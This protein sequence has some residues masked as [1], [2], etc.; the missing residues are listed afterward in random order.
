M[1]KKALINSIAVILLVS[2][3][4]NSAFSQSKIRQSKFDILLEVGWKPF[5]ENETSRFTL[6]EKYVHD[7]YCSNL[8]YSESRDSSELYVDTLMNTYSIHNTSKQ[9]AYHSKIS[10]INQTWIFAPL[11]YNF[12]SLMNSSC[13]RVE[14][15]PS[16]KKIFSD[17]PDSLGVI[18]SALIIV[19]YNDNHSPISMVSK[20]WMDTLIQIKS[21]TVL[22]TFSNENIC[23]NFPLDSKTDFKIIDCKEGKEKL[24]D[25]HEILKDYNISNLLLS[26]IS[27]NEPA[28]FIQ[29][30]LD[31]LN[32][33][34]V[35]TEYC[36]P[37]HWFINESETSF[38]FLKTEGI[39]FISI[40]P[41]ATNSKSLNNLK[42]TTKIDFDIYLDTKSDLEKQYGINAFPTFLLVNKYGKIIDYKIGYRKNGL[43]DIQEFISRNKKSG[44]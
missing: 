17:I 9:T 13:S 8:F 32:L 40:I 33:I 37:C 14:E 39:K 41:S 20:I 36:L 44:Y 23:I 19:N 3:F 29:E 2:A 30:V 16:Q 21:Y 1:I 12:D 4:Y 15:T 18:D 26:N 22:K 38:S 6:R 11:K 24:Y 28:H 10:S 35:F 5:Y 25:G 34:F 7:P 43:Q 31:S 42:R 27:K